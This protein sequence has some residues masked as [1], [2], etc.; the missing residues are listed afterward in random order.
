MDMLDNIKLNQG[1][2]ITTPRDRWNKIKQLDHD[3]VHTEYNTWS[4]NWSK[5]FTYEFCKK[6]EHC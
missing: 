1:R 2:N 6:D 4:K 3:K 5:D